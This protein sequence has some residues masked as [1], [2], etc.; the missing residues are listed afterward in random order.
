[1]IVSEFKGICTAESLCKPDASKYFW[2]VL[3]SREEATAVDNRQLPPEA[4]LEILLEE[5][6]QVARNKGS[7]GFSSLRILFIILD[8]KTGVNDGKIDREDV[9]Q[10]LGKVNII[11]VNFPK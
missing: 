4:S 2:S 8:I 9:S 1:V 6:R 5:V 7:V 11:F 10:C 3:T